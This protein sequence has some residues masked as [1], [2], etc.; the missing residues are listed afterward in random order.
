[1]KR[2]VLTT[3]ALTLSLTALAINPPS[4]IVGYQ[5]VQQPQG[6]SL[7]SMPFYASDPQTPGYDLIENASA[8]TTGTSAIDCDRLWIYNGNQKEEYYLD[9]NSRSWKNIVND[10]NLPPLAPGEGFGIYRVQPCEVLMTGTV[11]PSAQTEI[12]VHMGYQ[13]I[14]NPYPDYRTID[15]NNTD[16]TRRKFPFGKQDHLLTYESGSYQD[17][18]FDINDSRWEKRSDNTPLAAST[19]TQG[20]SFIY[21]RSLPASFTYSIAKPAGVQ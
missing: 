7:G 5:K 17:Y 16:I 3:I 19:Y 20:A 9:S 13:F 18:Y 11:I 14:S 1:M 15:W 8:I 4:N 6:V 10:N 21:Y 2:I 12:P